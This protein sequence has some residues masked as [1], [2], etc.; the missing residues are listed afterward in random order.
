[1]PFDTF[2]TRAVELVAADLKA[3]LASR[4]DPDEEGAANG[5]LP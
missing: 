2:N 4:I 5:D 3:V 1:V